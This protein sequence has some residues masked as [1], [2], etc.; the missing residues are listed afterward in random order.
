MQDSVIYSVCRCDVYHS[1]QYIVWVFLMR[2]QSDFSPVR[3]RMFSQFDLRQPQAAWRVWATEH[4][5][6]SQAKHLMRHK[7]QRPALWDKTKCSSPACSQQGWEG[8][9]HGWMGRNERAKCIGNSHSSRRLLRCHHTGLVGFSLPR[10]LQRTTC[11]FPDFWICI[12]VD[13]HPLSQANMLSTNMSACQP[14]MSPKDSCGNW[15][16]SSRKVRSAGLSWITIIQ[17]LV[18]KLQ[19]A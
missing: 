16:G 3:P 7:R 19:C 10:E 1:I 2:H 5:F 11:I 9:L 8:H 13:F 12:Y 17:R 6:S 18:S 15:Y 4:G 14:D